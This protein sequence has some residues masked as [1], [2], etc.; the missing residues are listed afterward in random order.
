MDASQRRGSVWTILGLVLLFAVA[1]LA[2]LFSTFLFSDMS[3]EEIAAIKEEERG[4]AIAIGVHIADV[5]VL[6]QGASI[7]NSLPQ[8]PVAIPNPF[9]A[10][11]ANP[12][13]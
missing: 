6:A 13:E 9:D 7:E 11:Y 8:A 1:G 5:E 12:F 4:V 3:P 2:G 10:I